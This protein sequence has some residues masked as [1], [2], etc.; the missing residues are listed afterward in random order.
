MKRLAYIMFAL[1]IGVGTVRAVEVYTFEALAID[2][3]INGQDHWKV[4]PGGGQATVRQDETSNGTQVVRHYKEVGGADQ[5]AYIT[6]TNDASFNF[7]PFSGS[8]SNAIIQSEVN[9]E[10]LAMFALGCDRNGDGL[11]LSAD[12]ELGPAFG[13]YDRNFSIQQAGLGSM[14]NVV[15]GSGNN[16][17]DW[18]R[19]QLQIDFTAGEGK[20]TGSL[21]Y[22]NLTDGDTVF[23]AVAGLT[24]LPL[25]LDGLHTDAHPSQWNAIWLHLRSS[26]GSIPCADNLI[27]NLNGILITEMIPSP[28]NMLR[29]RGGTGPYQVQRRERLDAGNW[30]DE[31][32]TTMLTN[33]TVSITADT[34]FFRVTQP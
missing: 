15:F 7:L 20:G 10:H 2:S 25:G 21:Y 16:G 24:D 28:D 5:S 30:V 26:G 31:G 22:M 34:G 12:G 13:V 9:G 23:Q 8:E 32:G 6:R 29:W 19:L 4:Q 11:L 14:S 18:Y 1:L 3:N 17:S 33:A 27:P